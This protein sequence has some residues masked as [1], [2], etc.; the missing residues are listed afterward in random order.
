VKSENLAQDNQQILLNFRKL[1]KSYAEEFIVSKNRVF[2]LLGTSQPYSSGIFRESLIRDFLERI[3]PK[4]VSIDSGFIYGYGLDKVKTSRQIDIII[5]DSSKYGPIFQIREF[6]VVP[7]ESVIAIITVKSNMN[8]S[9]IED[10]LDNLS[11]VIDLDLQF[12]RSR[13]DKECKHIFKP[14]GKYFISYKGTTN[15]EKT[16]EKISEYYQKLFRKN[17]E[18]SNIII[19]KL[20]EIDPLN[21]SEEIKQTVQTFLPKLISS[22]EGDDSSFFTGW[23]PP[24][25]ERGEQ[26]FGPCKLKRVPYLY[27]QH[28]II[29]LQF[30]KLIYHILSNVY[31]YLGTE[32]WSTLAAWADIHPVDGVRMGDSSEIVESEGVSLVDFNNIHYIPP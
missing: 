32:G 22:I 13:I 9:D 24:E 15:K 1:C 27:P 4:S 2:N 30:E 3:L 6:V 7:P 12:R 28:S 17:Q 29:T 18:Y 8:N 26:T 21:L 16:K 23:G 19:P 20:Q 31:E 14:I 10:G 5:W 11:S 25:D